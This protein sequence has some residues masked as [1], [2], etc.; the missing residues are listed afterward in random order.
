MT[1]MPERWT[2]SDSQDHVILLQIEKSFRTGV[3]GVKQAP[4]SVAY[5]D[6]IDKPTP[7]GALIR[8][9]GHSSIR[10]A[11]P[12]TCATRTATGSTTSRLGDV[13]FQ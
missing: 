1:T 8:A 12:A 3:A 9:V 6:L 5:R 10:Q 13:T 2:L 11:L 7:V 4:G